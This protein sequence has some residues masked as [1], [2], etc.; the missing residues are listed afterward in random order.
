[1]R[2]IDDWLG[3]SGGPPPFWAFVWAGG[4]A[5]ARYV[6]DHADAVAGKRV[7]DLAT[8]SGLCAIAAVRA[9][10]ASVNAADID[11][12]AREAVSLNAEVNQVRV[13]FIARDLLGG[14]PPAYD[15][16]LAGDIFYEAETP[17]RLLPWLR[18]AH[19]RGTHVLIG[20][21]GRTYFPAEELIRLAEYDVPTS[22]D[23]E[24]VAQKPTGVF[25]FPNIET[26]H[27]A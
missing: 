9:G 13:G 22:L 5:L 1:W 15:V 6:L 10:A 17:I 20:D 26:I 18:K 4:Q 27:R 14:T 16:I 19:V 23:L 25:A 12:L 3:R 8:G 11:P 24:G 7:L 21:P 2:T